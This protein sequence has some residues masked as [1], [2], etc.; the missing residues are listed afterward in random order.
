MIS[1]DYSLDSIGR[2]LI[3]L[4]K[5]SHKRILVSMPMLVLMQPQPI[6]VIETLVATIA[7]CRSLAS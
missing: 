3:W 7:P 1:I 5:Q 4:L 2:P 6:P